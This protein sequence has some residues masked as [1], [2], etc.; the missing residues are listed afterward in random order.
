MSIRAAV[1]LE[2]LGFRQVYRYTD[3]KMDWAANGLPTEG[4]EGAPRISLIAQEVPTCRLGDDLTEVRQRAASA[5][6]CVV[7]DEH[8]VILGQLRG[9]VLRSDAAGSIEDVM[10]PGPSTYRPNVSIQELWQRLEKH[11]RVQHVLVSTSEGI[12]L[13]AVWRSDL[14]DVIKGTHEHEHEP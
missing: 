1:R 12:L 11:A 3:G 5:G 10:Q 9:D 13:G 14:E 2:T 6:L 4:Q 8:G 7:T